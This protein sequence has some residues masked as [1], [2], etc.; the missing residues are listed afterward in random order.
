MRCYTGPKSVK[1]K[2]EKADKENDSISPSSYG[3]VTSRCKTFK[4]TNSIKN[5]FASSDLK[6]YIFPSFFLVLL[7]KKSR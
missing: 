4:L 3:A 1:K 5:E 2:N 6:E 7:R